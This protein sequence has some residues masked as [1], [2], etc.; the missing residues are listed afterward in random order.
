[1]GKVKMSISCAAGRLGSRK[2]YKIVHIPRITKYTYV[3]VVNPGL[4]PATGLIARGR[5]A[6][7]DAFQMPGDAQAT[8]QKRFSGD[9]A[10]LK[11]AGSASVAFQDRFILIFGGRHQRK[12]NLE[13][14]SYD[15][16]TG[17]LHSLSKG[18][19][20]DH[21]RRCHHTATL[22]GDVVWCVGGNTADTV[23]TTDVVWCFNLS[24]REWRQPRLTGDL[25]LLRRTAHGAC[26]HPLDPGCILIFGGYGHSPPPPPATVTTTKQQQ[27]QPDW[28]SDLVVIDTRTKTVKPITPGGH[29][30]APLPCAYHTF[31]AIADG[32]CVALFGRTSQYKLLSTR[33]CISIYDT[34]S[35]AW[36]DVGATSNPKRPQPVARSSHRACAS[37]DGKGV[38]VFGGAPA[39]QDT[40]T[41][42]TSETASR[43][44]DLHELR[45]TVIG[46][47]SGGGDDKQKKR[48][49]LEWW[50]YDRHAPKGA[51]P[52]ER[53]AHIQERIGRNIFVVA[54]YRKMYGGTEGGGGGEKK[55]KYCQD[56]WAAQLTTPTAVTATLPTDC[57]GVGGVGGGKGDEA[58]AVAV[59]GDVRTPVSA[60]T[61]KN[62]RSPWAVAV[63]QQLQ[64][65]KLEDII[66]EVSMEER[67]NKRQRRKSIEQ[68]QQQLQQYL[69]T[70]AKGY[71]R[72]RSPPPAR[73]RPSSSP[74]PS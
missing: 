66:E 38:V 48:V 16:L 69:D 47:G 32:L 42:T 9:Y 20:Q 52:P 19:P 70:T 50:A 57:A 61:W 5:C 37:G 59:P 64:Q 36:L 65:Q 29:S 54:G 23:V 1:M 39:V 24:T 56:V 18:P 67:A 51:W 26:I 3:I 44:A 14:H 49:S 31:T 60:I 46:G 73:L 25:A 11:R 53:A 22:V 33:Q 17:A 63:K 12:Y 2:K 28:L 62:A 27:Q 68:Q 13:C 6:K 71:P 21:T 41:T 45:I 7:I 8:W 15:T 55:G 30:H 4:V 43:L 10:V 58:V 40:H 35:N 34:K 74:P 72:S